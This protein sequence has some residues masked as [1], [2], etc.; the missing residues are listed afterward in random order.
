MVG[1][2]ELCIEHVVD[3]AEGLKVLRTNGCDDTVMRVRNAAELLYLVNSSCAHFAD[4]VLMCG[5]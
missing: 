2:L 4:E 1:K 5:L 3:R